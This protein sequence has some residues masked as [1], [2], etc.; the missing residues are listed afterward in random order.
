MK[1]YKTIIT[2]TNSKKD[3]QQIKD[4]ILRKK[5][6]PCVQI[7]RKI[8]SSYLWKGKILSDNENMIFIKTIK[9]NENAIID[10]IKSIHTYDTPEIISF[11]FDILSNKYKKWF[12]NSIEA[13]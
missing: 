2:T 11:D 4:S 7:I 10:Q 5:L 3:T 6:S 12:D 8:E 9:E 1:K 13:K